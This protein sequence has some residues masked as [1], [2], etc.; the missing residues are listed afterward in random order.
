MKRMALLQF[1]R[2]LEV[3]ANRLRL[4]EDLNPRLAVYGLFGGEGSDFASARAV[5]GA[6]PEAVHHLEAS[7]PRWKWQNTDLG[8]LDW[9]RGVGRHLA[10]DVLHVIQWDLLLLD[11]LDN[12]YARVPTVALG[13]TGVTPLRAIA[14][15]WHWTRVEPHRTELVEL[16]DFVAARFGAEP[17]IEACLGPGYCLPRAFLDLYAKTDV[18]ELGHDELRLPLFA[19]ILGFPVADTG[20]YPRWFDRDEER[21]FNA[22]GE[23]IDESTI[24]RELSRPGGRRA[25]HPFRRV[26]EL[27]GDQTQLP[28]GRPVNSR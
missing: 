26:F 11:S 4:L 17:P 16:G 21:Y 23:E 9:F 6:R 5:F 19:R 14:D 2:D 7:D 20:F 18:P 25:F 22:N 3:A 24:R 10:F 28:H 1:H 27:P 8:V 15:R 12:L 13:L